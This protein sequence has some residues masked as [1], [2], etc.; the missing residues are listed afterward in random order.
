MIDVMIFGFGLL[1]VLIVG[2]S[3]AILINVNNRVTSPNPSVQ[4]PPDGV[5]GR[6]LDQSSPVP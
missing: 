1:V 5:S 2:S 3:L 6:P 4:V